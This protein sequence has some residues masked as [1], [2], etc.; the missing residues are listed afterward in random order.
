MKAQTASKEMKLDDA[1]NKEATEFATAMI[2][3]VGAAYQTGLPTMMPANGHHIADRHTAPLTHPLEMADWALNGLQG[4]VDGK[5]SSSPKGMSKKQNI[6]DKI[7][8]VTKADA[9]VRSMVK[10]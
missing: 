6:A 7:T 4:F 2:P 9:F 1:A 8:S 10:S 3:T 5:S